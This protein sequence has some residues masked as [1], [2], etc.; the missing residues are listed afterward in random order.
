MKF[1]LPL[2]MISA[3]NTAARIIFQDQD[4]HPNSQDRQIATKN[5]PVV[6]PND[7]DWCD[8]PAH[9]PDHNILKAVGKQKKALTVM[10]NKKQTVDMRK[11]TE[12]GDRN[13]TSAIR[14]RISKTQFENI[15]D[16]ETEYIMPRAAKNK[17]GKFMFIV[18]Y[19]EVADEYIQLV[20]VAWWP[21]M[22][23][24]RSW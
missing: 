19:P 10:F 24:G 14:L 1:L 21:S 4:H 3:T 16:V 23:R 12:N 7:A 6:C 22:P 8:Q 5:V 11:E 2:L 9:Y 13:E 17:E 15:C 20:R 18:N